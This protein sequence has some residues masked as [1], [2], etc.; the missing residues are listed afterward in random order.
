M[1]K[2]DKQ[3]DN[4]REREESIM[5]WLVEMEYEKISDEEPT[6]ADAF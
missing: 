1:K 3:Y 5:K 2:F 6:A 4:I